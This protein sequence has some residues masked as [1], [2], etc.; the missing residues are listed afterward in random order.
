MTTVLRESRT[1]IELVLEDLR[2]GVTRKRQAPTHSERGCG[3]EAE[4]AA[5][6]MKGL[7]PGL[8]SV[9]RGEINLGKAAIR[10]RTA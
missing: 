9:R 7:L 6:L 2:G 3:F 8:E 10:Y 1:D 4:E 5:Q